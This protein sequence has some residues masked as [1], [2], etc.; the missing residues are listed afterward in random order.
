MRPVTL[1]IANAA[2]TLGDHSDLVAASFEKALALSRERIQLE[3][4]DVLVVDAPDDTIPEWGV[5]GYTHG[6]HVV[7]VAVDPSASL[8]ERHIMS[9]LVHE[10]HHAMRWRGPGCGGNLAQM[11]V[12][13][14]LAQLFEEE[15]LGEAPFFSRTPITDAEIAEARAT[16][17]E[18]RFSPS[19]WFFGA[20]GVTR[21]FGYAYGYRICKEYALAT[22]SDAALLVGTPSRDIIEFSTS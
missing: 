5:G 9:T 15:T 16:L 13:E 14:G 2:G 4:V 3:G 20:E 17:F 7:L 11:L 8:D 6:P 18:P 12:S 19:K 21:L 10:F 1:T 22:G